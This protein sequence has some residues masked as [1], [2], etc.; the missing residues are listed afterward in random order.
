MLR[1]VGRGEGDPRPP[2]QTRTPLGGGS[3]APSRSK[4]SPREPHSLVSPRR[5]EEN[6]TGDSRYGVLGAPPG[7]GGP[8]LVHAEPPGL[9]LSPAHPLLPR[10]F[11]PLPPWTRGPSPLSTGT[12]HL[13]RDLSGTQS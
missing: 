1:D 11:H 7:G 6:P 12:T 2:P 3:P 13:P 8:N 4:P 10:E 5:A 9:P